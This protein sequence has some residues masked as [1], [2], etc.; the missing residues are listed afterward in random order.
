MENSLKEIA[1]KALTEQRK[2]LLEALVETDSLVTSG[3]I[4]REIKAID[5]RLERI[6]GI[7]SVEASP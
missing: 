1:V 3:N 7:P 5:W 2:L 4:H 6:L